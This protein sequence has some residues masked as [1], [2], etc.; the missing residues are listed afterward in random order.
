MISLTRNRSAE[1]VKRFSG[2]SK[3]KL[4]REL[5]FNERHRIC[6]KSKERKFNSDRWRQAK[7]QLFAETR[8]KC[9]YCEAPTSGVAYGDVE[10]YRP[11]KIYWWL[12]YSYDNYLPSCT[13]CNQLFKR[14]RFPIQ[15]SQ[16]QGPKIHKNT[17][18][19]CIENRAGKITP[20]PSDEK[21]SNAFIFKYKQAEGPLLLNPYFDCPERYF[22]WRV[23]DTLRAVEIN[24]NPENPDLVPIAKA[25]I[26]I[27]GL[28]RLELANHRY[29]IYKHY[30]TY[31]QL[32]KSELT[33]QKIW[34]ELLN[35]IRNMRAAKRE[36]IIPDIHES[37][38]KYEQLIA[39]AR[40]DQ[41]DRT[42]KIKKAIE[43]MK[44]PKEPFAGMIRYFDTLEG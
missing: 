15:N 9:A 38:D 36:G 44:S 18:D 25:S 23:D 10:H 34:N 12:A 31:K 11:K 35:F 30:N 1:V 40:A 37:Y 8:G 7:K 6:K 19:R 4:E 21:K 43:R 16:M 28:Y 27:Y 33:S 26:D 42:D 24:P 17:T 22:T 32:L 39:D 2:K 3:R 14:D 13:I 5:L 29:T 20:D 41:Q